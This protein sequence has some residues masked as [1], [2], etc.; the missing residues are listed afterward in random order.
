MVVGVVVLSQDVTRA[1]EISSSVLLTVVENVAKLMTVTNLLL[2]GLLI[3][4]RTAVA[5]VVQWMVAISQRSPRQNSVSS[6]A[7]GRSVARKVVKRLHVG[8][9]STA[10]R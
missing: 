6:M 9:R 5:A 7:E 8:A 2:V 4:P 3:V 1:H 10:Q